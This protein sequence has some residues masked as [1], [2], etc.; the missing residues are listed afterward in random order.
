MKALDLPTDIW[1]YIIDYYLGPKDVVVLLLAC[2]ALSS[3]CSSSSLWKRKLKEAV[4]QDDLFVPRASLDPLAACKR[5]VLAPGRMSA[6]IAN[7]QTAMD[8]AKSKIYPVSQRILPYQSKDTLTVMV[9]LPGG[10][11]LIAK[12]QAEVLVIDIL[13]KE[14]PPQQSRIKSKDVPLSSSVNVLSGPS[15]DGSKLRVA[16]V[17]N[18]EE[19]YVDSDTRLFLRIGDI[20]PYSL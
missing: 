7:A 18:T 20:A 2:R 10:R 5:T 11:Y 6:M 13:S 14:P 19:G 17:E 15:A 3:L 9:L 12:T 8:E 1:T 16:I 4:I